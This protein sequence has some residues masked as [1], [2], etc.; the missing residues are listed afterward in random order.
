MKGVLT[1]LK[2]RN[3]RILA[4]IFISFSEL[5]EHVV[6][7]SLNCMIKETVAFVNCDLLQKLEG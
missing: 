1:T 4:V 3:G 6:K 7:G 2:Q 5:G